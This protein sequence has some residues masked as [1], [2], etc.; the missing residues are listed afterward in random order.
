MSAETSKG[1]R[2]VVLYFA[3]V[4][5]L[6][7]PFWIASF[8][9]RTRLMPGLSIAAFA[10]VVPLLSAAVVAAWA[11]GGVAVRNLFG[12]LIR[13]G[14]H[15]LLGLIAILVPVTVAA[16]SWL[17][18]EPSNREVSQPTALLA[19]LP[20]FLIAAVAEELGWSSFA[21][22]RLLT[23]TSVTIAGLVVGVVWAVW[24]IPSLIELERSAEWIAWWS[25]WTIAQRVIMAHLYVRARS[26]LW[27]PVLFHAATNIAWQAAPDAFDPR[28]EGLAMAAIALAAVLI[29]R[30][31]PDS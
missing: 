9:V 18:S 8:M 1:S 21:T 7:L 15:K 20:V 5:L 26:W 12:S 28:V 14:R 16:I 10:V 25:V 29:S 3:L 17:L 19:L 13:P 6:T 11:G 23:R 27:A 30:R 24:H 22:E 31:T 2:D 4:G